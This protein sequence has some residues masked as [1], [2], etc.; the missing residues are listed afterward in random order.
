MHYGI[1]FL[2]GSL[3]L[4]L[5]VSAQVVIS[6]IMYDLP[7]DSGADGGREWVEVYNSGHIFD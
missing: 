1:L 2:L 3:A 6:E 4:P 5:S 7:Q